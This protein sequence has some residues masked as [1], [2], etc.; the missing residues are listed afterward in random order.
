MGVARLG[1]WQ[2]GEI[3]IFCDQLFSTSIV[4]RLPG[5]DA[6][7][8]YTI[9]LAAAL[10][11]SWLLWSGHFHSPFLLALG[12]LSIAFSIY[13]SARMGIVD[14]EGAPAHLGVRPI[15]SY[16]LWLIKEI[17]ASNIQVT[18]III[19][20]EL[21]IKRNLVEVTASQKTAL[22]RVILAN[23]ITLTPGTVSVNVEGDKIIVHALSFEGADEDISGEM[24]ERVCR[25]EMRE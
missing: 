11:A 14:E 3:A 18:Q 15:T 4:T 23:S 13:L 24:D 19:D 12:A 8:K 20:P 21:P 25:L 5:L 22:G 2:S 16:T 9:T 1:F 17:V 6:K 10:F 7:L